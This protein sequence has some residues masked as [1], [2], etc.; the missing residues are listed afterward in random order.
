MA[1]IHAVWRVKDVSSGR[2]TRFFDFFDE[3]TLGPRYS[4]LELGRH[5]EKSCT[6]FRCYTEFCIQGLQRAGI[7][8]N[9]FGRRRKTAHLV[10]SPLLQPCRPN[11]RHA[12]QDFPNARFGSLPRLRTRALHFCRQ[13]N[14]VFCRRRAHH[15]SYR[16]ERCTSEPG[17]RVPVPWFEQE[18]VASYN[19]KSALLPNFRT[20]RVPLFHVYSCT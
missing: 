14:H 16:R 1:V 17:L 18:T 9:D 6:A 4:E 19:N 20:K 5:N 11:L 3:K 13:P 15:W 12:A 10:L 8:K 7:E 2:V